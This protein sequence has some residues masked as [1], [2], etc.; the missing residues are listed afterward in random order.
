MNFKNILKRKYLIKKKIE[1]GV[2]VII[3]NIKNIHIVCRY[4]ISVR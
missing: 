3:K 2:E 1:F 4:S